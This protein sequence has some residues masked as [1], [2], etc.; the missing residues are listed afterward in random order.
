MTLVAT[1]S[2]AGATGLHATLPGGVT[3]SFTWNALADLGASFSGTVLLR[4]QSTDSQNATGN[5]S[6]PMPYA[7][8]TAADLD[9]DGDGVLDTTEAAFGTNPNAA[10]SRPALSIA[11]NALG[12]FTFTWPTATGRTYK[13]QSSANLQTWTTIQ[14]GLTTGT[15]VMPTPPNFAAEDHKFYRVL[16]DE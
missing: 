4:T 15:W 10:N 9:S 6:D 2:P 14:S 11:K 5:W 7:V 16:A 12:T 8:N 1:S 13:L 3:H